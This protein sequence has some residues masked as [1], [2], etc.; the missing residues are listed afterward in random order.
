[1]SGSWQT[2]WFHSPRPRARPFLKWAGGKRGLVP[3]IV[4][5]LGPFPDGARYF[6][7]FLGSGAVFFSSFPRRAILSD[8]NSALVTSYEL[9]KE[10]TREVC[11]Y[12]GTLPSSPSRDQYY[13]IRDRFNSLLLSQ[14]A[15]KPD[16]LLALGS[17]FIWLNHTCFNGLY[18][19][20]RAGQFNVPIGSATSPYIPSYAALQMAARALRGSEARLLWSDYHKVLSQAREGDRVYLDPPYESVRDEAG[21]TAY[22]PQGF[23][24]ADQTDLAEEVRRLASV[25][26]RVVL[27][28]SFTP[29]IRSLYR[30]FTVHTVTARRSISRE[31]SGRRRVKE[32]VVVA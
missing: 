30:R 31:G 10:R 2:E 8:V 6:E 32:V 25:G 4:E 5:L 9:V 12:L 27:S 22:T 15:L 18:R 19:V 23:T 1:M 16:E 3:R 14:H 26:V 11:A 13:T 28:N 29:R 20:N 21:F 7:P 24:M 17:I